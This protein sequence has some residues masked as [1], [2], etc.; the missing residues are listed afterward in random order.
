MLIS[1]FQIKIL[2]AR[3]KEEEIN[4]LVHLFQLKKTKPL[5]RCLALFPGAF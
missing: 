3:P 5:W 4:K 1:H 2:V